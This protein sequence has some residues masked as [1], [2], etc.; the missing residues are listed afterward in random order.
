MDALQRAEDA[1]KSE[2]DL[3]LSVATIIDPFSNNKGEV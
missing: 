1:L 2:T 3:I